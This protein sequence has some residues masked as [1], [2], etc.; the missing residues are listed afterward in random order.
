MTL[1]S[2]TVV[3]LGSE[4]AFYFTPIEDGTGYIYVPSNLVDSYKSANGWST[5][6]NQI[7]AIV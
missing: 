4:D 3:T 1:R 6:A 5:Y 7:R 2:N